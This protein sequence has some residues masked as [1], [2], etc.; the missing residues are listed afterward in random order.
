M[1]RLIFRRLGWLGPVVLLSTLLLEGLFLRLFFGTGYFNTRDHWYLPFILIMI[2]CIAM[3][4]VGFYL[5]NFKRGRVYNR[6][7]QESKQAPAHTFLALPVELWGAVLFVLTA[8]FAAGSM[9]LT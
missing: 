6:F 1:R 8:L 2:G 5:N 4:A 7:N 9:N 3:T